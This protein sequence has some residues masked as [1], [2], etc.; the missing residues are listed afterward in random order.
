[1]GGGSCVPRKP[2]GEEKKR[3]RNTVS[4][5]PHVGRGRKIGGGD[6]EGPTELWRLS[7]GSTHSETGGRGKNKH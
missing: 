7:T 1:M 2:L 5:A 3:A 4:L 6:H